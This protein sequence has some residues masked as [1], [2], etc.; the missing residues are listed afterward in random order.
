MTFRSPFYDT[1]ITLARVQL[2]QLIVR[3]YR[4]LLVA[5]KCLVPVHI[6]VED[7]EEVWHARG[8][9]CEIKRIRGKNGEGK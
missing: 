2:L 7:A 4:A 8:N 6:W 5:Q 3:L 9:V 1:S